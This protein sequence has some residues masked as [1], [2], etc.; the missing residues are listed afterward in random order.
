MAMCQTDQRKNWADELNEAG[1]SEGHHRNTPTNRDSPTD[2]PLPQDGQALRRVFGDGLQESDVIVDHL[3]H[4]VG[5]MLTGIKLRAA[6]KGASIV[7]NS[8]LKIPWHHRPGVAAGKG[9]HLE[10]PQ[11]MRLG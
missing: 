3:P 6:R 5:I 2:E 4:E 1:S 10:F 11:T 7:V 9:F 8:H